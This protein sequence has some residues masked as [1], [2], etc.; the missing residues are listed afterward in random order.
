MR[1]Y[2]QKIAQAIV[3]LELDKKNKKLNWTEDSIFCKMR[4]CNCNGCKY[5]NLPVLSSENK[6]HGCRLKKRVLELVKTIGKPENIPEPTFF[7]DKNEILYLKNKYS[8]DELCNIYNCSRAVMKYRLK[9]SEV[10]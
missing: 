10:K 6:K 2:S 4:G 9:I 5:D 3:T 1:M 8:L 7:D